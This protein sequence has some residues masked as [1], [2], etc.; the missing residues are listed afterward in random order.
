MAAQFLTERQR[1]ILEFIRESV[2]RRGIAP[3]HREIRDRFGYSSYGTV[4]K[5]LRI[6]EAK[7]YLIRHDHQKRGV[8]LVDRGQ[9]AADATT[10]LPFLGTIAAGRPIEA[11]VT[12]E[13]VSV[14][15]HLVRGSAAGHFVLRVRGDS[16]IDEGIHDGDLVV[17]ESRRQAD[18]GDM[19]VALLEDEATLK[20]Y[21]PEG[22][23]V[24]LQPANRRMEPL[25]VAAET[26]AVQGI[27]V[28][29]IRRF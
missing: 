20:R 10:E 14:P 5:H 12:Q 13:T 19:I 8:E 29:L 25:R 1:A 9:E 2:D 27:A 24:R 26:L 23:F 28:G 6:L 18:E 16:M 17:I 15:A 11:V 21:Y 22:P 7:G 3:T 4:N